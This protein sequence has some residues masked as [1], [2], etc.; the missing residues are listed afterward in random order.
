[1]INC[2]ET[3]T[4]GLTRQQRWKE[5]NV[6][7]KETVCVHAIKAEEVY[8]LWMVYVIVEILC[9]RWTCATAQ[10]SNFEVPSSDPPTLL[11]FHPTD[12]R[13]ARGLSQAC[14]SQGSLPS[15]FSQFYP[16]ST[17]LS[18]HIRLSQPNIALPI[19]TLSASITSQTVMRVTSNLVGQPSRHPEHDWPVPRPHLLGLSCLFDR[20]SSTRLSCAAPSAHQ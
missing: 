20:M 10:H 6:I 15:T 14:L 19:P 5:A 13:L 16:R 3:Q 2:G 1:M 18:R 17:T 8:A 11:P 12:P 4:R 7:D 9:K